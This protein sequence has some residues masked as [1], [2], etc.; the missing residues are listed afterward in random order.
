MN[1]V[2]RQKIFG[3]S[4]SQCFFLLTAERAYDLRPLDGVFGAEINGLILKE[5]RTG[6]DDDVISQLTEDFD[7]YKLIIVRDQVCSFTKCASS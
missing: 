5:L 4:D 2:H 6:Q 3:T 1:V 7:K